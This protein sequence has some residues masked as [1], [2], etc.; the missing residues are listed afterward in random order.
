MKADAHAVARQPPALGAAGQPIA[1]AAQRSRGDDDA[2]GGP[3]GVRHAERRR[4]AY[5]D[6]TKAALGDHVS[7]VYCPMV[8]KRWLQ[9]GE[10]IKNPYFGKAMQAAGR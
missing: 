6:A 3:R 1:A 10:S 5:A 2:R 4:I 8:K 9:K 7:K